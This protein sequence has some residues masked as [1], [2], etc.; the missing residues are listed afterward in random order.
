[1]TIKTPEMLVI[2]V[3][4]AVNAVVVPF[5][6]VYLDNVEN[7]QLQIGY[8]YQDVGV[9][10]AV[11][12]GGA[13]FCMA[14]SRGR[15]RTGIS[16]FFLYTSIILWFKVNFLIGDYGFLT[17]QEP[18]WTG[19]RLL[20]YFE[21]L[22][23]A[24]LA[25]IFYKYAEQVASTIVV[26]G[27]VLV[28]TT[29][30]H[31]PA[32]LE[33]FA[34]RQEKKY[35]FV[36]DGVF[37]LSEHQNTILLV[38]DTMQA[39]VFNEILERDQSWKQRLQGFTFFRNSLSSFPKTYASMAALLSGTPY[40]NSEPLGEYLQDTYTKSSLPALL[41]KIGYDVRLHSFAPQAFLAH[42]AV[43]DNI[44]DSKR[45]RADLGSA[46][47]RDRRILANMILFRLSPHQLKPR[48]YNEG[49]FVFTFDSRESHPAKN[50]WL[51]ANDR[52]SSGQL[53]SFDAV[54]IDKF[55]KCSATTRT[56]PVFRM[57]H[58]EAAH[59]PLRYDENFE[60]IGNQPVNRRNL[61][62]QS[63]G[64]MVVAERI[65]NR[66]KELG[67]YDSSLILIIGDHGGGEFNAGL[68][69]GFAGL[70]NRS[71]KG[72]QKPKSLIWGAFPL[73]LVKPPGASQALVISDAPVELADI[74]ATV[75][76]ILELP[77]W[78][79]SGNDMYA[80]DAESDRT[81]LHKYYGYSGWNIDYILPLEEFQIRGFSWYPES[82]EKSPRDLN[83]VAE[84][85]YA[86]ELIAK[87]SD[88]IDRE[89]AAED[90]KKSGK[91]GRTIRGQEARVQ[92]TLETEDDLLL[93]L[94]HSQY[95]RDTT[96]IERLEVWLGQNLLTNW[97]FYPG[98][99]QW[100]KSLRIPA[101]LAVTINKEPLIF[102]TNKN[103]E[104]RV[105]FREIRL[106]PVTNYN[107]TP[108]RAIDFGDLGNSQ[109]YRTHGWLLSR[110]WGVSSAGHESGIFLRLKEMPE[111]DITL[112]IKLRPYLYPHQQ[113]QRL[114]VTINGELVS[115]LTLRGEN[116]RELSI[117]VPADLVTGSGVIDIRFKYKT[118]VLPPAELVTVDSK[119]R[120]IAI[121]T[122][123][124]IPE[125]N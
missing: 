107:Y 104:S 29:G 125:Q 122:L 115:E 98:D 106:D 110:P 6:H 47:D 60:Y 2:A 35:A 26:L 82:W 14:L 10:C 51:S 9:L 108:G 4:F 65:L 18:D 23:F 75:A 85:H 87:M 37:Q 90:W 91:N 93:T 40:D 88:T 83:R 11:L 102:K 67:V 13:F 71:E 118:P 30:A 45:S 124:L 44:Q 7:L 33:T 69:L 66:L 8:F 12:G 55:L 39:D 89:G 86:G 101:E 3:L 103:G 15:L 31:V 41:H 42:P 50:C 111:R 76:S 114:D 113:E 17:G 20:G 57:Y 78:L 72:L 79:G 117:P 28:L 27:I 61:V 52:I 94:L 73:V 25:W 58:L 123:A 34:D 100:K 38:L 74:P 32:W 16:L 119:L 84:R 68:K 59:L 22:L 97:E 77:T 92:P 112:K 64:S 43:A 121:K 95:P 116:L 54:F 53:A 48:V 63:T 5:L 24:L 49:Q 80:I 105:V 109:R 70:P 36:E 21:L 99:G 19:N 56:E 46:L 96:G 1:M 81:R 120:A 62:R